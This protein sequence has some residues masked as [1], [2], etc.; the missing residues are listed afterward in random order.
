[1]I[2]ATP[3]PK[4]NHVNRKRITISLI[5]ITSILSLGVVLYLVTRTDLVED[6]DSVST[7]TDSQHTEEDWSD[8]ND[9]H[10]D[11]ET[12]FEQLKELETTSTTNTKDEKTETVA[13]SL[14]QSNVR[15]SDH[16]VEFTDFRGEMKKA[17]LA[18]KT[19]FDLASHPSLSWFTKDVSQ[20]SFPDAP[21]SLERDYVFAWV[22]L[23]PNKMD[24]VSRESFAAIGIEIYDGMGEYR[25]A[26]LP[27]SKEKLSQLLESESIL[28]LGSMPD[29]EKIGPNFWKEVETSPADDTVDVVITLMTTEKTADWIKEIEELGGTIE[30][31]DETI[32]V[33]VAT[34]PYRV[35]LD[36]ASR[37]FVQAIEPAGTIE[38]LLDSSVS[39]AGADSLRSFLGIGGEFSG[40]TGEDITIGVI[41]S[42][43]N[44]AHPDIY[45]NRESICGKNFS[46]DSNGY[47]DDDDLWVDYGDHGTHVTGI[48]VGAGVDDPNKAGIAPNVEHIRFAKTLNREGTGFL[49][50]TL[51]AIDYFSEQSSC[52]WD[53][54]QVPARQPNV[55]NVSLG[56][57]TRDQ[58]YNP[59]AKKLDWAVWSFNQTYVVAAGND[60][61]DGYTPI[62]LFKKFSLSRLVNGCELCS[63]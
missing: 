55:V 9:D 28:A 19:T 33:L 29:N 18:N 13:D 22:Q 51:K 37:D 44:I 11:L 7:G 4:E 1:M 32:R 24:D 14:A 49:N 39:V 40:I 59:N 26:T 30:H 17:K 34:T 36:L 23:N 58:G 27:R 57:T 62:C 15:I 52:E 46:V 53:S 6:G 61:T 12:L 54:Q 56:G 3:Q 60:G 25:R 42:G 10:E 63:L 50:S 20:I 38:P 5:G 48:F 41:D 45:S 43:L 31:W 16:A 35:V 21:E 47:A 2:G 8:T